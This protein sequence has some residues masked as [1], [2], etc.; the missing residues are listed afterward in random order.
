[1]NRMK[2]L[3]YSQTDFVQLL[4][5]VYRLSSRKRHWGTLIANR[6]VNSQSVGLDPSRCLGLQKM[7]SQ[8]QG[9]ISRPEL[10]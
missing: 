10:R 9:G 5:C 7:S 1:M 4:S 8:D 3:I 6:V 2:K